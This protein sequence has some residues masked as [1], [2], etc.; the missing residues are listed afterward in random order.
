MK[1]FNFG[2]YIPLGVTCLIFSQIFPVMEWR[3]GF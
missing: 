3:G 1:H 2:E